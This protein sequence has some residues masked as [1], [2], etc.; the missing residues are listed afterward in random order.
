MH[1]HPQ[2]S[3]QAG[4]GTGMTDYETD[5]SAWAGEQATLLRRVA[6]GERVNDADFDWLHIA[7]ELEAVSRRERRELRNRTIRL[8]QHL[9][10]WHYQPDH[11][12]RSWR[13]TINTQRREI[14]SLLNDNPSLRATVPDII[15]AAYPAARADAMAE[16][17][18]ISLPD[19]LPF[20]AAHVLTGE[21]PD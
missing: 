14:E 19:A 15:S 8:L 5:L 6:A 2:M 13:A 11:R 12:S 17:G 4:G 1:E 21:L 10:K 7:E 3:Y 18:L 16:T 9:L 20:D